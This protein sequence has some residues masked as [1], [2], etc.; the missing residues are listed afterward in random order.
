M[1]SLSI[2]LGFAILMSAFVAKADHTLPA[3]SLA[4]LRRDTYD[5]DREVQYS[6]LN[7]QVRRTV[8]VFAYDVSRFLSCVGAR[9]VSR[10]HDVIPAQ[11]EYALDRVHSS[12]YPVERYLYDTDYD[13]PQVYYRYLAV[14]RDIRALPH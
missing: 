9:A 12:W 2:A 3:G 1:R 7:Y 6:T 11:C 14:R 8:S 10:D 13:Y 5:L 4:H